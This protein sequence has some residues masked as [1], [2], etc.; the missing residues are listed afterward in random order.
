MEESTRIFLKLFRAMNERE[1]KAAILALGDEIENTGLMDKLLPKKMT[2]KGSKPKKKPVTGMR[3][4]PFWV[5]HV[6]GLDKTKTGVMQLEGGWLTGTDLS[7]LDRGE[8]V[9]LGFRWPEKKY[10]LLKVASY[11]GAT[12]ELEGGPDGSVT[13]T[14]AESAWAGSFKDVIK[15]IGTHF[16]VAA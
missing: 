5:R 11:K 12:L 10:Y 15:A 6:K 9:V 4:R 14:G 13:V 16:K 3:G 1:K 2:K 7:G 8:L